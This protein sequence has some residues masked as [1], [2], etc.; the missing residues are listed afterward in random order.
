[1]MLPSVTHSS[2]GSPCSNNGLKSRRSPATRNRISASLEN[3]YVNSGNVPAGVPS[4]RHNPTPAIGDDNDQNN[5]P[6]A[7]T[8]IISSRAGLAAPGATSFKK[9]VPSADPSLTHSSK[10]L[11]AVCARKTALSPSAAKLNGKELSC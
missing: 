4:V 3:G 2:P 5:K 8:N 7:L 11:L 6:P 10:P 1:M 9:R